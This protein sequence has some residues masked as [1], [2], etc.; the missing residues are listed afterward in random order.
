M[1][2]SA[3]GN[4]SC[5]APPEE[6]QRPARCPAKAPE[7]Y[8]VVPHFPLAVPSACGTFRLRYLLRSSTSLR[9]RKYLSACGTSRLRYLSACGTCCLQYFPRAVLRCLQYFAACSTSP[10]AVL[11]CVAQVLAARSTSRLRYSLALRKY[12]TLLR[13]ASTCCLQYFTLLRCASTSCLQYFPL[14]VL[15]CARACTCCLQYLLH[16]STCCLRYLPLAVLR[17]SQYLVL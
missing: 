17:C 12:F 11:A 5:A 3:A 8:A 15:A 13:C 2:L 16:R 7:G 6:G 9:A 14:A 4:H 10:L 1:S